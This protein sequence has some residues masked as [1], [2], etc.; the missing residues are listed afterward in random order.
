MFH[1]FTLPKQRSYRLTGASRRRRRSAAAQGGSF[2]GGRL[3]LGRDY[4][5]GRG[6]RRSLSLLHPSHHPFRHTLPSTCRLLF[7]PPARWA[8]WLWP[9][10]WLR[11]SYLPHSCLALSLSLSPLLQGHGKG[12]ITASGLGEGKTASGR[13]AGR[14]REL[15]LAF[16]CLLLSPSLSVVGLLFSMSSC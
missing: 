3:V 14:G 6:R 7:C 1:L 16:A 2:V 12:E 11:C 8:P 5:R 13:S 4:K 15:D 9:W 10:L